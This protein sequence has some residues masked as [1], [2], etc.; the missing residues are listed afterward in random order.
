MWYLYILFANDVLKRTHVWKCDQLAYIKYAA[1][2][3]REC[4]M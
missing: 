4:I 1:F 3:M 2:G